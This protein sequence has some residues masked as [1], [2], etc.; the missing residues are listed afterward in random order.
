M[1]APNFFYQRLIIRTQ[2]LKPYPNTLHRSNRQQQPLVAYVFWH[3]C[4]LGHPLQAVVVVIAGWEGHP[5]NLD[6]I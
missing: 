6:S 2:I 1:L 5:L 4:E 3:G